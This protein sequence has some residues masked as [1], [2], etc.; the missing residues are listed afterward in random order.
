MPD[1]VTKASS[2]VFFSTTSDDFNAVVRGEG[3]E[4]TL[5]QGD[6]VPTETVGLFTVSVADR[7]L[8]QVSATLTDKGNPPRSMP[9]VCPKT[10]SELVVIAYQV[11]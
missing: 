11:V 2:T 6:Q 3:T 7:Q 4:K 10:A 8:R 5:Q 9:A 1:M